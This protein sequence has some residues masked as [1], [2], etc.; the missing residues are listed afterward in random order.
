VSTTGFAVAGGR[1]QRMGRDK[2]LLPWPGGDLLDHAVARLQSVTGDVR[3]L[4]GAEAR[5]LDRRVP[6]EVDAAPDMGPLAGLFAALG[7]APDC[8]LLLGVDLPLI[9]VALLRHLAELGRGTDN[10]AIVP[11]SRRGPEPLCAVYRGTCLEPVRRHTAAGQLKMT[12]FWPDI[13]VREVPPD[14]L[15][16]FG[17]PDALFLNINTP[18]DYERALARARIR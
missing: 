7:G 10:D 4:A 2:A 8:A 16:A 14:E 11:V 15:A 18:D 9:P 13:R 5:Y 1:S 12:G 3:I 6:V 17:D